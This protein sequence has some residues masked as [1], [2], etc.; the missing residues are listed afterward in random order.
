MKAAIHGPLNSS[1][2]PSSF[3]PFD[4]IHSGLSPSAETEAAGEPTAAAV[5]GA[6]L[7]QGFL[8]VHHSHQRRTAIGYVLPSPALL[9][10]S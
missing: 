4:E 2:P 3:Q 1:L 6:V 9:L 8:A 5:A 7:R 10:F